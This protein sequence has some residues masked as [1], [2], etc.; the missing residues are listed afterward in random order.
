MPNQVHWRFLSQQ[1]P[2]MRGEH[3]SLTA[4]VKTTVQFDVYKH[5]IRQYRHLDR[6]EELVAESL[7]QHLKCPLVGDLLK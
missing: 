7:A 6:T 5:W 3:I 4:Q 2:K 1:L